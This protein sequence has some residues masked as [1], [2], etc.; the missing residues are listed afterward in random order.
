MLKQAFLAVSILAATTAHADN[1]DATSS[2]E[3]ALSE[4]SGSED[5]KNIIVIAKS[6]QGPALAFACG[7][8]LGLYSVL[9][10]ETEDELLEQIT[11]PQRM[12]HRHYGEITVGDDSLGHTWRWKDDNKTLEVRDR[13]VGIKLLN[14]VFSKKDVSFSFRQV[15]DYALTLA[16]PNDELREFVA[17]CPVTRKKS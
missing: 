12:S 11:R 9:V 8:E 6:E 5:S 15:G 7:E 14:G 1:A 2:S 16:G 17:Q 4:L 13:A 10:Y 3:W